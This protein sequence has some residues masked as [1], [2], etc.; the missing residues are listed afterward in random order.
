REPYQLQDLKN[1]TVAIPGEWT[2]AYM[3]LRL[4]DPEIPTV[5]MAFDEIMPAV[6]DGKVDA[7]LLIHEG[8]LSY[9]DENVHQII[10][11]G[12]WWYQQTDGLPLPLGGNAI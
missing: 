3:A 5:T 6:L 4:L 12:Q 8:Q 7:G 1:V 11:L 2:S 9:K 10:D